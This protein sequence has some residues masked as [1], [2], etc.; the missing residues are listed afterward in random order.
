MRRAYNQSNRYAEAW[1]RS[2]AYGVDPTMLPEQT[3]LGAHE[4]TARIYNNRQLLE[5]ALPFVDQLYSTVESECIVAI[6]DIDG[7]LLATRGERLPD[8]LL[9]HHT[10]PG[11][12][13]HE[14]V[15]GANAMGTALAE[16]RPVHMVGEQHFNHELHGMSCAAAPLHDPHGNL[17]GSLAIAAYKTEHSPY[18]LGTVLSIGHAIDKAMILKSEHYRTL[19]LQEK[20]AETSNNLIIVTG[21]DGQIVHLNE[22]AKSLLV[23]TG[24]GPESLQEMFCEKSAALVALN[25]R[26]ALT[27]FVEEVK[28]P[29]TSEIH[30]IFWDAHWIEDETNAASTLLL[31]G[32]DMTK[33]VRLERSSKQGERLSTMG[34]F[35]A[36]IA[37]EIRNPVAV[38][39]LAMQLMLKQEEFSEK[40]EKKGKMILSELRRIE[41]LV[42]HFLNISKP[43]TPTFELCNIVETLRDTCNLMQNSFLQGNLQLVEHY[44]E[45]GM[46]TADC[47]QLQQVFLNLLNNAIDATPSGGTIN[48]TVR[49]DEAEPQF[50]QIVI[51]DTGQGIPEDRLADVFE[52]FYTTKSRGTG[53]GL[54]NAKSIIEAHG[55]D[56]EVESAVDHGTVVSIW[57]PFEPTV[58]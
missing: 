21:D 43:Q 18:M 5:A 28:K 47:D 23:P 36:Q 32:R 13:W 40:S 33:F 14:S 54:S 6:C 49:R 41:D 56:M 29:G 48:V 11:M 42:N 8:K 10:T 55:G 46:I 39:K 38:I 7:Y 37:H 26:K 16:D 57:L 25:G 27:D 24:D 53:L 31:V 22:A 20:I 15:Y 52:P 17:V 35:A 45:I 2:K 30:H 58:S 19:L 44:E 3:P 34:K 50:V 1:E 12:C 9:Q 4:L 51:S